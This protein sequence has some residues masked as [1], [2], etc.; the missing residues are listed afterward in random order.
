MR[1]QEEKIEIQNGIKEKNKTKVLKKL[2]SKSESK[3]FYIESG[4]SISK[5]KKLSTSCNLDEKL[6]ATDRSTQ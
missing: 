1:I 5:L 4:S 2:R 3:I 6:A